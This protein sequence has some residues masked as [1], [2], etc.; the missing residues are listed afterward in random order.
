MPIPDDEEFKRYLRHFRPVA[1][2]PLPVEKQAGTR[3]RWRAFAVPAVAA[4]AVVV[5]LLVAIRLRP[6]PAARPLG[7]NSASVQQLTNSQPLTF[8]RTNDLLNHAESFEAAVDSVAFERQRSPLT[9]G[10]QS[11]LT[12]LGREDFK[13]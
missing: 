6:K 11:A 1:A 8:G 7:S 3:S 4:L 10:T 2:R 13:L 9:R 12:A 5:A